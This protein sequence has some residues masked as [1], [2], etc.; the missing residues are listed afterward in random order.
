MRSRQLQFQSAF[1]L[2]RWRVFDA[3]D[4]TRPIAARLRRGM[5]D[6]RAHRDNAASADDTV[7]RRVARD[8]S[9]YFRGRAPVQAISRY[10][11]AGRP[12]QPDSD[13]PT[14]KKASAIE[15]VIQF[16]GRRIMH[17]RRYCTEPY[18]AIAASSVAFVE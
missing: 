13:S 11:A 14:N 4:A 8:H 17:S 6:P 1:E 12:S 5:N 3:Q 7:G 18:A 10:G 9:S 2:E 16:I 15:T